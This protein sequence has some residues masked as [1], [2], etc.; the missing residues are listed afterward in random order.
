MNSRRWFSNDFDP[1]SDAGRL[2]ARGA[3]VLDVF[4][5]DYAEY[6]PGQKTLSEKLA[7]ILNTVTCGFIQVN[8]L[9]PAKF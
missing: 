4:H 8:Q 5:N 3:K 6:W 2:I 9:M 7:L 1:E